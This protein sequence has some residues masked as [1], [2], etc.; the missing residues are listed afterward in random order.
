MRIELKKTRL[1]F[2]SNDTISCT[3]HS[4][5][6]ESQENLSGGMI[7]KERKSSLKHTPVSCVTDAMRR[8]DT[9]PCL[10]LLPAT[11]KQ[12]RRKPLLVILTFDSPSL[13]VLKQLSQSP[14]RAFFSLS[15]VGFIY[16]LLI[17][18]VRLHQP[19]KSLHANCSTANL[20]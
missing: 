3:T 8:C 1:G 17:C 18:Q 20:Q 19:I 13:P 10:I 7:T 16:I 4:W 2:K 6:H 11:S 9:C 15:A 12:K 5:Q 14:R